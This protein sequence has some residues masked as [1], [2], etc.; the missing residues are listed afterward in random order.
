MTK[1]TSIPAKAPHDARPGEHAEQTVEHTD[2]QQN[3]GNHK[4]PGSQED[5][6][7]DRLGGTRTGANIL[8]NPSSR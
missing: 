8:E 6:G 4:V 1:P 3:T 2:G 5:G 7:A